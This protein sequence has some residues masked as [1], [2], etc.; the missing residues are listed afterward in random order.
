MGTGNDVGSHKTI[1]HTL[2]SVSTSPN[3]RIDGTGFTANHHRDV[4]TTD[5]F[6]AD[7]AHFGRFGHRVGGFDRGHH[8]AGFDHAKGNALSRGRGCSSR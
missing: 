7:Q 5:V 1:T 6:A 4:T 8:A 3:S 2:A